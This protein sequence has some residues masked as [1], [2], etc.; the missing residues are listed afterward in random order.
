MKIEFVNNDDK[1]DAIIEHLDKKYILH[2]VEIQNYKFQPQDIT[3]DQA[4][5]NELNLKFRYDYYEEQ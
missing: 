4:I 1:V 2:N 3:N 5:D